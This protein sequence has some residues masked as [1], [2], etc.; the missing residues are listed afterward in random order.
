VDIGALR[1]QALSQSG[2]GVDHID[3]LL[4]ADVVT[5]DGR[6]LHASV[7]EHPDLFW[8]LRGAGANFGVVTSF[9]YRLHPVSTVLGGMVVH[10]IDRA[11][12]VLQFY[13][14]FAANQPD[15][16]TT[17]A[18]CLTSPDGNPVVAL[19]ACYAGPLDDGERALAPLRRFG[20][21]L[22]DTFGGLAYTAMQAL[23]GTAF[24]DGRL[25]YWKSS[26]TGTISD[27]AIDAIAQA[28]ACLPSLQR[29]SQKSRIN[30]TQ[31]DRL[32]SNRHPG[33]RAE[34]RVRPPRRR[35]HEL[36]QPGRARADA[37]ARPVTGVSPACNPMAGR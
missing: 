1:Q 25:N 4:S 9:E 36:R 6:L 27:G 7:D 2:A 16:L 11:R 32:Q 10:P 3:N 17:Y 24:P 30:W 15:E 19:V 33:V 34:H 28:A 14:E 21:P 22:A 29:R 20:T 31:F 8:A 37:L 13:R 35:M 12:P 26:L 18:A 23:L 5:A